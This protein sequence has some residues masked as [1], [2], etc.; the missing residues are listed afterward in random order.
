MYIS[1]TKRLGNI[2]V[3]TRCGCEKRRFC[4]AINVR[5]VGYV[6]RALRSLYI[7]EQKKNR[8][9]ILSILI[10]RRTRAAKRLGGRDYGKSTVT[11]GRRTRRC[12]FLCCRLFSYYYA[13]E[14]P[15]PACVCVRAMRW[16]ARRVQSGRRKTRGAR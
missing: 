13:H 5:S 7:K 11:K 4:T 10:I 2:G 9:Y 6:F 14:F 8:S 16:R 1:S 3:V 12:P 15:E